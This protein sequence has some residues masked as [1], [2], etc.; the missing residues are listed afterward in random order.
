M[1]LFNKTLFI[2]FI[3][4]TIYLNN[5]TSNAQVKIYEGTEVIPT[6]KKGE[7]LKSPMFYT[8]RSVQGAQG[9]VYP[10]PAQTDLG[11]DLMDMTYNMV[12]LENE[13]IIVKVLP[14]FGGRLFSAIDKT[15]GH[16]LFHTNSVIK[17]DLI[18][19]LGAWVSGGIEWCFPHHHRTTTMLPSDYR[20]VKNDD[21][22]ATIWIGE[23][24][25]TIRARGIVGMTLHPG[26]SYIEVDYRLNN[27]ST[28]TKAFLFW[29][30]VAITA[31]EDFRTFW[32][33]SQEIGVFHNNRSFVQWPISNETESYGRTSYKEG[34]DLTWWKNHPNPV[35]FFMWD[36]KEGFIGGYDYGVK[37]G[38]VHV[39][40]PHRNNASKL[41][42][43]GPG[44]QGQ[45]A[46]RKLTDD[47]KAYVE[48]MTG[49]FSNNQPD[50]S[51]SLPH[52]VKNA[53]NYWYPI[54][55]LEVVKNSTVNA[56]VALHMNNPKT[57]FYGFNTTQNYDDA[58]Y[59]L[60]YDSKIIA[61]GSIGINPAKPY[62]S[63]Y[64]SQ[65]AL[66]EYKL[67]IQLTDGKGNE[68]VSY[69]PYKP[70]KPELPE[71]QK[72]VKKPEEI[73]S[74]EDLYLAGRFVEQFN[75]PGK[76]PD[77]Y[78]LAALKKSPTDYRSNIALGKRRVNQMRFKDALAYLQ[79]ASDKLNIKYYQPKEGEIYYYK[80]LAHRALGQ[81][82]E[83]YANFARATWYYQW[84]SASNFQL[85][86]IE[87]TNGNYSKALEYIQD[88]YSTN[89]KDGR[90]NVLYSA[91]LRQSGDSEKALNLIDNLISYDPLN[92]SALYEKGLLEGNASF[93]EWHKNMQDLDNNYLEVATNYMNAGLYNDGIKLLSSFDKPNSPLVYYYLAWFY[94]QVE[95][96]TKTK[97]YLKLAKGLSLDYCFPYRQE[98]ESVFNNAIK[99][100][101]ENASAFYLL[102]NLLYDNRKDEA[103]AA[104]KKASEL[105]SSLAMVYRNLAF[106]S[107]YHNKDIE[108]AIDYISKAISLD[109]SIPL[110]YSELSK[111]FEVSKTDYKKCLAILERNIEVVKKDVQA[112]K[113]LV[114][115]YNLDGEYDKS[116]NF[117][118]SHRFRTWEGGRETYW[119]YVDANI[120]K[121]LQ[122]A[123]T[124]KY[125]ESIA[126]LDAAM[127]YP[128]NLEV[129]KPTHDE[130]NAMIHYF[131]GEVYSQMKNSKKAKTS[132]QQSTQSI[133][134]WRMY[135]L[136][137]FQAES[138]KKLGE[139]D[140]AKEIFNDLIE[141]AQAYRENGLDNTLVAVEEASATNNK[142][143][144]RSYYLEALGNKG[145]GNKT[146]ADKLFKLAL[147]EYNNNIWARIMSE[148]Y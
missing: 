19:T 108:K 44:L 113:M 31:N 81:I 78:Y 116:L 58:K 94:D 147:N 143:Y 88:A 23:T 61:E 46:R 65:E 109:N 16:E 118:K 90:I 102:G 50:Y 17:P 122:L 15:N 85:A 51:W 130:K 95:N 35:S 119:S 135:D 106:S 145:L 40:D 6:Y 139:P 75:R 13:Y 18:G 131:K 124:K 10:Y 134:T 127:L 39:G 25:K 141:K 71:T 87:S 110:W 49:T 74:V 104:W 111:Y 52:S 137:Y 140:K 57:V 21:G 121:A 103:I 92:F 80:G 138:Y 55:D 12:Y 7:D 5:I 132:Y 59:I 66:D 24:E 117:L 105:N 69:T 56:S 129:G 83:A 60:K 93:N 30:N 133:N 36:A 20:L 1:K 99:N 48:L 97:H 82:E 123:D 38:T 77:D 84:F 33:P 76:N 100:D 128:E 101:P 8:G 45:N 67:N 11:R 47:G 27:T 32:P 14:A 120:L 86:Q 125:K 29:A 107:Y 96:S 26:K 41:W 136:F 98:T 54:R 142:A 43:F 115:L 146:E 70:K 126:Y 73:E 68:L 91:L 148:Y 62:T 89:N 37:A 144:S 42:Q 34:V 64:K 3:T 63:T 53:K 72:P 4:C 28:K 112:P 22:S 9:R 114:D 79:T 2:I